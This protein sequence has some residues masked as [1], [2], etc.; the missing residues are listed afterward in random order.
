MGN[1]HWKFQTEVD[2]EM[3]KIKLKF[4]GERAAAV[5]GNEEG[6]NGGG[7]NN[8]L[9]HRFIAFHPKKCFLLHFQEFPLVLAGIS[10]S[11]SF[12]AVCLCL[13]S[14]THL[15]KEFH[16]RGSSRKL[17]VL[18]FSFWLQ[19]RRRAGK[20]WEKEDGVSGG[21]GEKMAEMKMEIKG[22]G[23]GKGGRR[24][25]QKGHQKSQWEEMPMPMPETPFGPSQLP[26]LA[27][28]P[29]HSF[30]FR[31]SSPPPPSP[32]SRSFVCG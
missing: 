16:S 21:N 29:F 19:H 9:P 5:K 7:D 24:G 11:Q 31:H 23:K 32:A 6:R 20:G 1:G 26:L 2:E 12:R 22:K 3:G 30:P 8:K 18:F 17:P 28:S 15:S 27:F 4:G 14:F 13:S 10:A 25:R